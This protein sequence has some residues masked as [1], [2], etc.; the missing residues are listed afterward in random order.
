MDKIEDLKEELAWLRAT[1]ATAEENL[2]EMASDIEFLEDQ[3]E[4][5][6]NSE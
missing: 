2:K 1:H 4:E 3:I 5:L 6:E